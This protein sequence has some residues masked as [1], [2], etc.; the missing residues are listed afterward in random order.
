MQHHFKIEP[1]AKSFGARVS[2]IRLASI[3]EPTFV[4]LYAAWLDNVLAKVSII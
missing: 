1:L 2:G 3:D 4:D